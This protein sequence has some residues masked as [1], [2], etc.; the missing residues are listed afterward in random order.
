MK[1]YYKKQIL[2]RD[3]NALTLISHQVEGQELLGASTGPERGV[4][5]LLV[6]VVF[7]RARSKG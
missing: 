7:S 1:C 6:S 4:D 5:I 2:T 3:M